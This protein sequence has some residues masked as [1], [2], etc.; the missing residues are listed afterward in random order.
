METKLFK[1]L[2]DDTLRFS[3]KG[4]DFFI[5]KDKPAELPDCDYVKALE[6]QGFIEEIVKPKKTEK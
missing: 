4:K 2:R 3:F 1:Y 6:A 5:D